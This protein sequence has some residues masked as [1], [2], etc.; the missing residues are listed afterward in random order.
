MEK[1]ITLAETA[2][3]LGIEESEVLKLAEKGEIIA[4]RIGGNFL[5]FRLKNIE[6]YKQKIL[7]LTKEDRKEEP[8]KYSLK[9]RI[10]DFFY[11]YD[12]Y[13]IIILIIILLTIILLKF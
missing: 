3:I 12:F 7:S 9:D 4:Y 13:I 1:F 8:A 10:Y 11:Y 2:K 6:D 5:R